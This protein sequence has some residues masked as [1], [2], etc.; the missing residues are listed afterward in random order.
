[1]ALP[2]PSAGH[3]RADGTAAAASGDC[4]PMSVVVVDDSAVQRRFL[5]T[6]IEADGALEVIGEARPGRDAVALVA[7]LQPHVVLMD[8]HLP[9]MN[10]IEAIERIMAIRPTPI[11]VHS[12]FVDGDDRGNA[13]AALAAGAVDVMSKPT[14][15]APGQM[16]AYAAGLRRSLRLAGRAKVI[17]HPRAKLGGA[18]ATMSTRRLGQPHRRTTT[19][20]PATIVATTM[21]SLAP[22]PVRVIA[23]GASTGG[24]HALAALLAELPADLTAAVVVVQHMAE[25]FMDGLAAWLDGLCPLPVAV[26]AP[27]GALCPGTV[28]I[29]PS[30]VN[31]IVGD[32][33]R[34]ATEEPGPTQYHVPGIDATM[35]SVADAVGAAA[36]GV[37]LTG[38]GRDGAVGLKRMREAG[39]FAIVQDEA[40]SA[41]YGMP[42]AA[43]AAEAADCQLPLS[44]IGAALRRLTGEISESA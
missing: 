10:G 33:L 11:L 13:T 32:Q 20:H 7:R 21:S 25:G 44:E 42:A 24:P 30:G 28:T 37:V 40:S 31:L 15:D 17:T 22:R 36:I 39:A 3:S 4:A 23:I 35:S 16:D 5:R 12:A 38:M 34:L 1:M 14:A 6:L 18:G 27:G 8:L 9:V 2:P 26:G 29:A 19:E 41:V 43:M